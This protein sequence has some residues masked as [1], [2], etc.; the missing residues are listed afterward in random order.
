MVAKIDEELWFGRSDGEDSVAEQSAAISMAARIG[1]IVGAKT[2]PKSA[3]RLAELTRDEMVRIEP[4]VNVLES[5][6][7]LSAKLLRLVNSASFGLRIRCT[8]VRHAATLVGSDRLHQVATTAAV[9]DLFDQDSLVAARI[10]EHSTVV[11]A[12]SRY[13]G[14][15]L[16]LPTDDLF[17]CGFLHDIGKLMM[18]ETEGE[19][20]LDLLEEYQNNGDEMHVLERDMYG[21]DHAVLGAHVLKAWEIPDPVPKVVAFHHSPARAYKCGSAVASM[22]QTLRLADMLFYALEASNKAGLSRIAQSES[23]SYLEISEPQLAAMWPELEQLKERCQDQA[24]NEPVPV[25]DTASLR[26]R[27]S[28]P[29]GKPSLGPA[30]GTSLMPANRS[31]EPGPMNESRAP[32]VLASEAAERPSSD[33]PKQFPCVACGKASFGN[34]C[35]ACGGYACPEHQSGREEWCSLCHGEFDRQDSIALVPVTLKI[36]IAVLSL[37]IL[38]VVFAAAGPMVGFALT[39][40]FALGT[41]V[42]IVARSWYVRWT[43]LRS[44]HAAPPPA[45][46]LQPTSLVPPPVQIPASTG[47]APFLD[48]LKP[49]PSVSIR[50]LATLDS[51]TI[52]SMTPP[53]PGAEHAAE[54]KPPRTEPSAAVAEAQANATAEARAAAL[55]AAQAQDVARALAGIPGQ[56]AGAVRLFDVLARGVGPAPEI[57]ELGADL[58]STQPP[59]EATAARA[60]AAPKG[61]AASAAPSEPPTVEPEPA[62]EGPETV[63]ARRTVERTLLGLGPREET[64]EAAPD[65]SRSSAVAPLV[66]PPELTQAIVEQV[67]QRVASEVA[68][69]VAELLAREVVDGARDKLVEAVAQK[70]AEAWKKSGPPPASARPS[71]Q[72]PATPSAR[73]RYRTPRRDA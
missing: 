54:D 23:A 27:V 48:L 38:G 52:P 43:F 61:S 64:L 17:T 49:P 57:R 46:P 65:S 19:L 12:L 20:Y 35:P 24:R 47:V 60:A 28:I 72:H 21:F 15:H 45:P 58:P 8:S 39:S 14:A 33:G 10:I 29:R 71:S 34:T 36:A 32:A 31:L 51:H 59:P 63:A 9:L 37:M 30:P 1:R 50:T 11:G 13:L 66:M 67:T 42:A 2:F 44:R 6:P 70:V 26:P 56:A 73:P 16:G 25:I 18:L 41:L 40:L 4:V 69:R 3:K 68:A 5:D 62:S 53:A 55:P 7:A 22:V